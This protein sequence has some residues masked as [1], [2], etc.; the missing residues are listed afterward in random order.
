MSAEVQFTSTAAAAHYFVL[1]N[2][3]GEF[4]RVTGGAFE[5]FNAGNW[6]DYAH[7]VSELGAGFFSGDQP[8]G[9]DS[10][11]YRWTALERAGGSP[12][13]TDA[14]R[15]T[16]ELGDSASNRIRNWLNQAV[17]TNNITI[18]GTASIVTAIQASLAA[19][20]A[21]VLGKLNASVLRVTS[22]VVED[23]TLEIVAGDDYLADDGRALS[24]TVRDWIGPELAPMLV[25]LR[26]MRTADYAAD[27]ASVA[28]EVNGT[29]AAAGDDAL[30]TV[31]LTAAQTAT[32]EA[33]AAGTTRFNYVY[34]LLATDGDG[35]TQTIALAGAT[36]KR[37]LTSG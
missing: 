5:A 36:V 6:E 16:G 15:A 26:L 18:A 24:W 32:L 30:F 37:K 2:P 25:T 8:A 4:R 31:N 34:Q 20:F 19:Q 27:E 28:L 22:A 33:V 21:S 9:L 14:K 12:A 13:T 11:V 1:Q 7:A 35:H 10:T 23:A 17:S 3:A 29:A